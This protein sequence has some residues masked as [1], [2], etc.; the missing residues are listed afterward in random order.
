[1]KV[2]LLA[3]VP[4]LGNVDDV[5]DVADGYAKN[6]L[7]PKHLAV[8]A[9][10]KALNEIALHK[11]RLAKEEERDLQEA[12]NMATKLDGMELRFSEKVNDKGMLYS[13]VNGQKIS[14]KLAGLGYPV[15]KKQIIVSQIKTT[16]EFGAKIK[17]RHGLEASVRIIV[18]AQ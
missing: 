17:F 7:F 3:K 18:S 1:M 6:L 5:K 15:D 8:Q 10:A 12:Q 4:G 13:A 9:S 11:N 14:D 2:I 16:G